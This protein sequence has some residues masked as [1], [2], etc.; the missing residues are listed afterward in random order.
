MSGILD[1]FETENN[2]QENINTYK[3]FI[4]NNNDNNNNNDVASLRNRPA[5]K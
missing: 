2:M 1:M 3:I 5:G 4:S